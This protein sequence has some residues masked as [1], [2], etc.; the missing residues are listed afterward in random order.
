MGDNRRLSMEVS[1][2]RDSATGPRYFALLLDWAIAA[3]FA[4]TV[5]V[6]LVGGAGTIIIDGQLVWVQI[7]G[8]I[9][10][11]AVLLVGPALWTKAIHREQVPYRG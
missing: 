5:L 8:L 4:L 11:V 2:P 7:V 9:I 3:A 6:W 10:G 1:G